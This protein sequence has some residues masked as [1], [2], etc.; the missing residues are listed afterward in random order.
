MFVADK[1]SEEEDVEA[2]RRTVRA[3]IAPVCEGWSEADCEALIDHIVRVE[4]KYRAPT[5]IRPDRK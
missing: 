4:L 3:R 5:F 2:L 1:R